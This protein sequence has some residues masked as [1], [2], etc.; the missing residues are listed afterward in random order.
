PRPGV[1]NAEAIAHY[2]RELE[3]LA[4][5]KI[6]PLITLQHFTIP[7]WVS[8]R[9][10][11]EW[12]GFPDAFAAFS[13]RVFEEIGHGVRDWIT[14]NE[15]Q[16]ILAA[17]FIE[18]IHPPE[19]KILNQI[20]RPARLMVIA[21]ARAYHRLHE[22]AKKRGQEIRV[23]MAHHLRI[24]SPASA[25][26]PLDRWAA[27]L[28]NDL[29]NWAIP[30]A[31]TTG[32]FKVYIP[33]TLHHEEMIPEA[34]N[35]QDF[36]GVNYYS[37][38]LIRFNPA[39]P[40]FLQ[41]LVKKGAPVSDLNWEIY[42]KGLYKLLKMVNSRYGAKPIL[43]TENG[44]ADHQDTMR[45]QFIVDHLRWLKRAM[46]EG[47]QVENYCHWSLMDNYEWQEGFEPRFG[48]YEV[49]YSTLERKLRPSGRLFSEIARTNRIPAS[50]SK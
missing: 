25:W 48:L 27:S 24:F 46:D 16:T 17:G 7:K 13:A 18:G 6:E 8:D 36:I 35:T 31:M 9:G 29:G 23:G 19:K 4:T 37:R 40:G 26:N 34:K 5:N 15:P 44:L 28:L 12:D 10:G 47:I 1:W 45:S 50:I 33:F 11:F 41:R 42:P 2:R 14:L 43:I 20:H 3:L 39:I 32:K 22:I 21:H 30:D 49:D 38:D